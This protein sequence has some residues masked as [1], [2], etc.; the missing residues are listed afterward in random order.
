MIAE[1]QNEHRFLSNFWSEDGLRPVEYAYQAAKT[2]DP[3]EKR[4]ILESDSPG[5]AKR[6]SRKVTLRKDWDAIKV[7][8]MFQLLR[9]KFTHPSLCA[10]LLATGDEE[11]VEG[12][13]WH[14]N[15]W[16]V[17]HCGRCTDVGENML[18]K[19][20]MQV[21]EELRRQV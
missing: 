16:G 19:L 8:V 10:K 4:W 17:C 13:R 12:N 6:R 21:R 3:A 18:G 14:D 20:L 9:E 11:L 5:E 15:F 1:F 7:A 2:D